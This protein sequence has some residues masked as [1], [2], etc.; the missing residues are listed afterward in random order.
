MQLKKLAFRFKAQKLIAVLMTIMLFSILWAVG[1]GIASADVSSLTVKVGYAGGTYTTAHVFSAADLNAMASQQAFTFIDNMPCPVIDSATGVKLTDLLTSAG[2]T[3]LSSVQSFA[4]YTTD[5]PPGTP[6]ETLTKSYLLD[7]PR[8]YLPHIAANWTT[9]GGEIVFPDPTTA[10][11]DAT[12]VDTMI[13]VSD[14]WVRQFHTP[15]SPDYSTQNTDTRFRLVFGKTKDLGSAAPEHTASKSAKWVNEIDVTEAA[16]ALT[17]LNLSGSP[18]LTYSGTSFTY[19]LGGLTLSGVDQYGNAYG[20]SGQPVTWNVGSG[21]ATV[22][23]STL[24]ITGSGTV[25]VTATV[26]TVTSNTLGLV[27]SG[28]LKPPNG[29]E[30]FPLLSAPLSFFEQWLSGI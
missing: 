1:P 29:T 24:T 3:N 23:G 14:H 26:D 7:T 25:N 8:Y 10:M 4:F 30:S 5:M 9:S 6:Y 19:D 27:V 11:S 21:P 12:Q 18:S 15:L 2:I 28:S 22:L 20:I 13:A 17:T 16:P